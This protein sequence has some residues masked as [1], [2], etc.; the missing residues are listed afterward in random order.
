VEAPGI[1]PRDTYARNVAKRRENDADRATQD[2]AKRREVSA[3]TPMSPDEAIRVAAK[4]AI[5]AGDLQRAR[6]LLDLLDVAAHAASRNS[7]A[8]EILAIG[9]ASLRS[10]RLGSIRLG[11]FG[12]VPTRVDRLWDN[13]DP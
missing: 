10:H 1:E 8:Q 6:A 9:A 7:H 2:D 13:L 11:L 12:A 5:D 4:V 3:S